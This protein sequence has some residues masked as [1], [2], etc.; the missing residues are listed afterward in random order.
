MTTLLFAVSVPLSAADST[1]PPAWQRGDER[2]AGKWELLTGKFIF[3][4]ACTS[5]HQWGPGYWPRRRWEEYLNEFP[6]NHR[7]D[8]Q[9]RYKDLTAMFDAGKAVPTL[10]QEQTALTKFILSTAPEQELPKAELEQAFDGFPKVGSTAPDFS[11]TDVQG[12]E[13]SLAQLKD[14]RALVLV[15]SRAHW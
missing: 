3:Q 8:M 5:C 2:L 1:P 13:F 12:R 14:K 11:I 4:Q 9:D 10:K 7:P 6:G 15:F